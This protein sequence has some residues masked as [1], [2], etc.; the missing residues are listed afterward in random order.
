MMIGVFPKV[1][2]KVQ[3]ALLVAGPDSPLVREHMFLSVGKPIELQG[4]RIGSI[5]KMEIRFAPGKGPPVPRI[6]AYVSVDY[7]QQEYVRE[8]LQRM[9]PMDKAAEAPSD[10]TGVVS[11]AVDPPPG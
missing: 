3:R 5:C 9:L 4:Q 6:Y 8:H 11:K 2:E 1:P 10:V 7:K